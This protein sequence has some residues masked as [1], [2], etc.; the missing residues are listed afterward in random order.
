VYTKFFVDHNF[1]SFFVPHLK[2]LK[3]NKTVVRVWCLHGCVCIF[4]CCCYFDWC[5]YYNPIVMINDC[6]CTWFM[7][8][9]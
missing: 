9:L 8:V 4:C 3:F 7:A 2:T 6:Y 1:V 5:L